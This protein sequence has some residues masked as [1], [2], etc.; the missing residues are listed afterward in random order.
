MYH[1]LRVAHI[2]ELSFVVCMLVQ[3]KISDFL[4]ESM[5]EEEFS[6]TVLHG[7][8]T[9]VSTCAVDVVVN[10]DVMWM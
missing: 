1:N 6:H 9:Y 8:A 10:V 4:T 5:T 7:T 2:V 3:N